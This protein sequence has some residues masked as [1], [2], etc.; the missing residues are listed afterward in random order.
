MTSDTVRNRHESGA[1][2]LRVLVG[3]HGY[4]PAG[5]ARDARRAVSAWT[6]TTVRVLAV[7]DVPAPPFTSVIPP[8]RRAYHAARAEWGRCQEARVQGVIDEFL[9]VFPCPVETV[10]VAASQGDPGRT[11]A[12]HAKHW[13]ADVVVVAAPEL[14]A[15]SWLWPGRVH[16]QVVRRVSCAVLV[17]PP[18]RTR[19]ERPRLRV[20]PRSIVSWRRAVAANRGA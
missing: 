8:A 16:E 5:W 7:L 12:E 4:E 1:A 13:P 3:I 18:P 17:T 11:I 15:T 2:T 9:D 14:R 20:V 10:R 19:R 6:S